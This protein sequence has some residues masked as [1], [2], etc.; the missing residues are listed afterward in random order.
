[1]IYFDKQDDIDGQFSILAMFGL[2]SDEFLLSG[3][4]FVLTEELLECFVE[5]KLVVTGVGLAEGE[6]TG[7][8]LNQTLD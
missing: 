4:E 2:N 8:V 6:R 5:G 1:M 3:F 7:G